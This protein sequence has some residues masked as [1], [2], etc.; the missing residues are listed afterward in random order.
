MTPAE[1]L[2]AIEELIA[3]EEAIAAKEKTPLLSKVK[4]VGG[5]VLDAVKGIGPSATAGFGKAAA[6]YPLAMSKAPGIMG[7]GFNLLGA[8]DLAKS[9][10][11]YYT[12]LGKESPLPEPAKPFVE[13]AFGGMAFPGG[14]AFSA[15]K[16]MLAAGGLGA[17]AADITKKSTADLGET[18]SDILAAIAGILTGGATG[19]IAGP[20]QSRAASG[21]REALEG[22]SEKTWADAAGMV[23]DFSKTGVKT[24]TLAE[25]FPEN[26]G[27][28]DLARQARAAN[29]GGANTLK[30]AT[31]GREA[32]LVGLSKRIAGAISGRDVEPGVVA[33]QASE[34]GKAI[35]DSARRV[36]SAQYA[37][38][39]ATGPKVSTKVLDR[40][41]THM[42]AEADRLK[43]MPEKADAYREVADAFGNPT[44]GWLQSPEDVKEALKLIKEPP[45]K[46]GAPARTTAQLAVFKEAY[47]EA[48]TLIKDLHGPAGHPKTGYA[49]AEENF[50]D[51]SR[52]VVNPLKSGPIG[53][54][55]PPKEGPDV[56]TPIGR[57]TGI[58]NE[59][60]TPGAQDD[61]LQALGNQA[62][63]AGPTPLVNDIAKVIT[64]KKLM[65]G[66]TNPARA[67]AGNPGST[68]DDQFAA[69][70][71]SAGA[72]TEGQARN[73]RVARALQDFQGPAGIGGPPQM[74]GWQALIR[75]FRTLD[76]TLTFKGE[77]KIARE[78]G[79]IL[80]QPT[81][82]GLQRLREISQFNPDVRKWVSA[83]AALIPGLTQ[84][85][86]QENA[87]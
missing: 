75:P 10:S 73:L 31:E 68:A 59:F 87:Q 3:V 41:R 66:P 19:L 21:V 38:D 63:Q 28:M 58:L 42:L 5:K 2:K 43:A 83:N 57:L 72:D 33:N 17:T 67:V 15:P 51:A 53:R 64:Q 84:M 47:D 50:I 60:Q 44:I 30:L 35:I 23:D 18:P 39:L 52:N 27:V 4:E 62:G 74:H 6:M 22:T 86:T 49:L 20:S 37:T 54:L 24:A 77:Q 12:K 36:R 80:T 71:K 26:S 11:D 55:A 76:M 70:M 85:P 13:G 65:S 8:A 61:F 69:L 25:A 46:P 9:T 29:T 56:V 82:E 34:A 14:T 40:F 79:E 32:D 1:E 48:D 78:I 45:V 7:M 16:T 81:P